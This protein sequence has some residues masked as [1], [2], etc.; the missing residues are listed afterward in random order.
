MDLHSV[1]TFC[2]ESTAFAE[3]HRADV[4]GDQRVWGAVAWGFLRALAEC[5][6]CPGVYRVSPD[7]WQTL[8]CPQCAGVWVWQG[9]GKA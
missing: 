4:P 9:E 6:A 8:I 5:P 1:H 3:R 2:D 7:Q